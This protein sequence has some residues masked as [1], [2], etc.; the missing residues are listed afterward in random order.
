MSIGKSNISALNGIANS[1]E[2]RGETKNFKPVEGYAAAGAM[3]GILKK[4]G[5]R[6][7]LSKELNKIAGD[8]SIMAVS[9]TAKTMVEAASRERI[10]LQSLRIDGKAPKV[11]DT[12]KLL[13]AIYEKSGTIPKTSRFGIVQQGKAFRNEIAPRDFVFRSR[14]F[15]QMEI[16]YFVDPEH[17]QEAFDELWRRSRPAN[18]TSSPFISPSSGTGT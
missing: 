6:K 4:D 13:K 14:E 2:I 11:E 16:E 12:M 8:I 7:T 15:E 1:V 5:I 9:N 17:W 3:S 10:L 18:S